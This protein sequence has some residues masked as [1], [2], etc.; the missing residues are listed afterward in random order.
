[1]R[2]RHFVSAVVFLLSAGSSFS[3]TV[4][5][6]GADVPFK[7]QLTRAEVKDQLRLAQINGETKYGELYGSERSQFKS[8]LPRST[9]VS[10]LIEAQANRPVYYAEIGVEQKIDKTTL[11]SRK[12]VHDEAVTFA[13]LHSNWG[14]LVSHTGY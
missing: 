13:H 6:E 5:Y 11:R 12:E 10:E 2:C 1:M 4:A 9:V 8:A 14:R 3:Q 7:S